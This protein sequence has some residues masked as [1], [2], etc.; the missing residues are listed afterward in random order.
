MLWLSVFIKD[1]M[2]LV[3]LGRD[4]ILVTRFGVKMGTAQA[5]I[6]RSKRVGPME[7]Y[8]KAAEREK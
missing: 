3:F 5:L 1:V 2:D 8:A 7:Q 4:A 6:I